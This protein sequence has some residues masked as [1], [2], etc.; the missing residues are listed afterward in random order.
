[1]SK[2]KKLTLLSALYLAQGLPYGFFTQAL[3]ILLRHA[4]LSLPQIG[5]ANFLTLPWALKFLWAPAVDR[6]H[7]PLVGLRRSWLIPL[8]LAS[9]VLYVSLA[10]FGLRHGELSII[11][12]AF[13]FTN[14][15][16][17]SQDIATDALAVD[18]LEP[19]ERG[20]ANGVQVAGYRA[21]MIIGGGFLLALFNPLGWS[22][23]MLSMATLAALCTVP[24]LLFRESPIRTGPPKTRAAL[25]ETI[26]FFLNRGALK[27]VAVLL[28]Y[29]F[30]HAA[31]S[32]MIRPWLVDQGYS[33]PDIGWILGTGGFVAGFLG[34]VAGGWIAARGSRARWL[35]GLGALQVVGVS[36]YLWPVLTEHAA[37]KVVIASSLDNFT[38][39]LATTVLFTLMMDACSKERA[40]SD[41]TAQACTVVISQSL[42]AAF[43]GFAAEAWGYPGFFAVSTAIGAVSLFVTGFVLRVGDV[44]D[45]LNPFKNDAYA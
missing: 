41:Y 2:T 40:A 36:S 38:S 28:L 5:L 27:W 26:Q 13:L 44:R 9:I 31:A 15:L 21:G 18:I 29:K 37:F 42:A 22:G 39:G 35:V 16:A 3:P 11:L 23:V 32:T 25:A 7:F 8:Q 34:A 6:W 24:V 17:A 12:A 19:S 33:L 14:L 1:M 20:W 45:L 10:F 43:A 4:H 30:G